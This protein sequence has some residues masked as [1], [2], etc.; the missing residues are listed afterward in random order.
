M[1]RMVY[2]RWT[3]PSQRWPTITGVMTL[4][5]IALGGMLLSEIL[6][7]VQAGPNLSDVIADTER[8]DPNRLA[9]NTTSQYDVQ[10]FIKQIRSGFFQPPRRFRTSKSPDSTVEKILSQLKLHCITEI[11]QQPIAYIKIKGIGLRR[12]TVGDTV[13]DRFTVL[14]I[15]ERA[16]K[17]DITGEQLEL[18]L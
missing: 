7:P 13:E 12:C 1:K 8:V 17:I 11:D 6:I 3:S 14:D 15:H 16:V 18:S 9:L 2:H 4:G 5:V 10:P